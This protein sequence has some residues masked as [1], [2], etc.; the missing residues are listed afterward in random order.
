M[1]HHIKGQ[2]RNQITLFPEALDDFVTE[3][4]PVRVVDAFVDELDLRELGFNRVIAKNTGRPGY[5]PAALLKLYIYGYLN[6]IQSSRRLEKES[7]RNVELM[8][9]LERLQPDFKTI[10][11]FRKDN[12][13]GITK[14][15]RHFIELCRQM[16]MFTDAIVAIDGS[17]FKAVN[18]KHN[19]YTP[20]KV[21]DH[22]A[23]MEKHIENYLSQLETAD[24]N[25]KCDAVQTS[26]A[27]KIAWVKKR[28]AELKELGEQVE[29]HP[30][31]Q[32]ST[33]DPDARLLK[34]Q[35]IN[36]QVCYNVQSTVDTK[37][38]LIVTHEVTNTNDR[39]KLEEMTRLTQQALKQKNL[40]CWR[41][42]GTTVDVISKP[43]RTWELLYLCPKAIH[44]A[45]KRKVYSIVLY[46]NTTETETFMYALREMNCHTSEM[47]KKA[48]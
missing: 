48:A 46:S 21:K 11:D 47:L 8:W 5:H 27:E 26:A 12:R 20:N 31:K 13:K 14:V 22:I 1:S 34:T 39:G 44:Q 40:L 7:H 3:E 45:Q 43:R 15:C 35:G 4:N 32:L 18:S 10:A 2:G 38:H 19:N 28:V 41:T 42:R 9:L 37:H 6:R 23:R 29:A 36:R 16:N 17:K 30:D 33:V 25:D 24:A